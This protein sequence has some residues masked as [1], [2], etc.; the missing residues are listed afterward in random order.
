MPT[1]IV[2]KD[3]P[4]T[5]KKTGPFKKGELE[6]KIIC[7]L[8]D[9]DIDFP[10]RQELAKMIGLK[11][12]QTIYNYFTPDELSTLEKN[13]LDQRRKKYAPKFSQ[14]DLAMIK[15]AIDGDSAA[16]KLAYQR[17]EGWTEKQDFNVSGNV[18]ITVI[19]RFGKND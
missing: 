11:H 8:G 16:A 18:N 15:K 17:L 7:I 9:P 10:K 14:I 2:P 19:D 13:G 12:S 5:G 6:I 3:N 4:K 1:K